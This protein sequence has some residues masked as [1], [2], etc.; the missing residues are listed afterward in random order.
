MPTTYSYTFT[1]TVS[2]EFFTISKNLYVSLFDTAKISILFETTKYF[3]LKNIKDENKFSKTSGF[4][5]YW[6]DNNLDVGK[7]IS[8]IQT[9]IYPYVHQQLLSFFIFFYFIS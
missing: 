9:A 3:Q 2:T 6:L 1:K 8:N 5:R 7:T 4:F